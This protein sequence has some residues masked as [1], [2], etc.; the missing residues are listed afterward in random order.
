MK[1][2]LATLGCWVGL[3]GLAAGQ[4]VSVRV[5]LDQEQYL[6]GESL[7][8]KVRITNDSGQNLRLGQDDAWLSFSVE[9]GRHLPATKRASVP[10]RG[11]F[12][13]EP[14][15]TGVKKVDLAPFYELTQTGRYF[16]SATVNL[17]QWRQA[18][19]SKPI[20]FDIIKGSNLWEKDFGV[21]GSA[22]T[23]DAPPEL[24]RYALVETIH[25]NALKLY[26]RLTDV[27]DSKVFRIYPLGQMVSF[28][29]VE[30]QIDRFSNLHVLYQTGSRAFL[31]C[32]I[33]PDGVL[34][35]RETYEFSES[36]P[37]LHG[38]RDGRITV[39]GGS[40]RFN[41]SDLPPPVSQSALPDAKLD[42]P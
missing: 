22:G 23:G 37:V 17:P 16:V 7:V 34:I 15:T 39:A 14:S 4:G 21:P 18:I 36:R 6:P 5:T 41:P 26:F 29:N 38:E 25:S 9:D 35:A 11:E 12:T 31:H 13:L 10:V 8:I 42:Q 24:R 30:P 2:L 19:Q 1:T 3:V 27:R 32:L 20:N 33:N 40:R 28:S